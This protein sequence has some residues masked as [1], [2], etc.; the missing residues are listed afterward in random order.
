MVS[1]LSWKLKDEPGVVDEIT[2]FRRNL[3]TIFV[4]KGKKEVVAEWRF[5]SMGCFYLMGKWKEENEHD[6]K[7]LSAFHAY[8]N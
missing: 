1:I 2:K 7:L 6:Q 8:L 3:L 4:E 5:W